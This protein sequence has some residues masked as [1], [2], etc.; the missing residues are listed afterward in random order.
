MSGPSMHPDAI[1]TMINVLLQ[2]RT[3]TV[4]Q[5]DALSKY[6]EQLKAKQA[7]LELG[8]ALMPV[9]LESKEY[10]FEN[11]F[12]AIDFAFGRWWNRRSFKKSYH[13]HHG[14]NL[15]QRISATAHFT[16]I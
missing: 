4:V 7:K 13:E 11:M 1:Q 2:K 3:L 16:K 9:N 5:Y 6:L 14:P 10:I 8:D 12:F 15:E